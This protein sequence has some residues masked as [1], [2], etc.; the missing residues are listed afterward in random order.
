MTDTTVLADR[1]EIGDTITK[2]FVYCDQFRWD[3][4]LTTVLAEELWF[5]NGFGDPAGPR[6]A[7]DIVK[8]W[9]EGLGALDAVHHQAGNHLID[10]TGDT[11]LAHAD[12]IAVHVK[13]DAAH[14]RTR[15]FVGSYVLGLRRTTAGWRIDRFEYK[16][17]T[18]EG[19]AD[20]T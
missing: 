12:S 13:N 18:I 11:A 1:I 3:E 9:A 15:T 10:L 16:L 8:T 17:K 7:T 19:N 6:T 4:M 2:L 20:L 5:D 14:G